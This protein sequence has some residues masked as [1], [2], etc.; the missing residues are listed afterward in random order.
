MLSSLIFAGAVRRVRR[1]DRPILADGGLR[2]AH[3]FQGMSETVNP[4]T[5]NKNAS[6]SRNV[7][8]ADDGADGRSWVGPYPPRLSRFPGSAFFFDMPLSTHIRVTRLP[9]LPETLG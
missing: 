5:N 2:A 1:I 6:M 3:L 4:T 8:S 9:D 7:S